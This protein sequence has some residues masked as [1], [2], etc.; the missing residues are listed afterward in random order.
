MDGFVF[1]MIHTIFHPIKKGLKR[2]FWEDCF[3]LKR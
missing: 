1:F 2:S 3:C